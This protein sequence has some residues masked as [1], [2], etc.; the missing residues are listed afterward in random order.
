MKNMLLTYSDGDLE[1]PSSSWMIEGQKIILGA[2][3][4]EVSKLQVINKVVPF[5]DLGDA[6]PSVEETET[7]GALVTTYA[8]PQV[9]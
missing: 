9:S 8:Q 2:T 5:E 3:E 1:N 4:E 6:K 7:C